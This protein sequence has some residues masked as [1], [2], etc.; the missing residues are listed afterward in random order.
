MTAVPV[1]VLELAPDLIADARRAVWLPQQRTLVVPDVHLGFAWV[2]RRR[3]QLLP[4]GFADDTLPRLEALSRDYPAARIVF[5]GDLVHAA[6]E[7]EPLRLALVELALRL[8]SRTPA[9]N[10]A[11]ASA[12]LSAGLEFT[13][14]HPELILVLGNHDHRLPQL[15]VDWQVPIR[16]VPR[17]DLGR[18]RLLH[19]HEA[20]P[21]EA[22][23]PTDRLTIIGHEHP[24]VELGAGATTRA[25][26]P[27]FALADDTL[28]VPAFSAWAAG[29]N[30]QRRN[31]L[32]PIAQAARFHTVLACVGP[33]LL[34]LPF[35][36]LLQDAASAGAGFDAR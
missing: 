17:L 9:L 6:C 30:L 8:G 33:R 27:A 32:G 21:L 28:V 19:G 5:L 10:S 25:K 4:V 31:H 23:E 14:S 15:L 34:R 29:C 20:A 26:C 11:T 18:F 1:G 36:R 16:V 35:A 13:V 22:L 3:G 7:L 12:A 2:Q 24:S